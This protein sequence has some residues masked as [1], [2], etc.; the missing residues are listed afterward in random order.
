MKKKLLALGLSLVLSVSLLPIGAVAAAGPFQDISADHWASSAVNQL[1]QAGIMQGTG[2]TTF[3]PAGVF[4]RAMFV[5]ML[6]RLEQVAPK[7]HGDSR[8]SDVPTDS[9]YAPYVAWASQA[10]LVNGT[11]TAAFSPQAPITREQY[12]TILARYLQSKGKNL[13][14]DSSVSF[15]DQGRVSAYAA[16]SVQDMVS[17]GLCNLYENNRVWPKNGMTR[18]EIAGLFAGLCQWLKGEDGGIAI[19]AANPGGLYA[20]D[21]LGMTVSQLK[22][23]FGQDLIYMDDWKYGASL[24]MGYSDGRLPFVLYVTDESR[25]GYP[26]NNQRLNMVEY[27]G[28]DAVLL[29]PNI[30]SANSYQALLNKGVRGTLRQ[31][32]DDPEYFSD[33]G[34]TATCDVE[35]GSGVRLMLEWYN[36]KNPYSAQP[37]SCT[38]MD[39]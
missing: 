8:F 17:L 10:G 35:L 20:Q 15:G 14:H 11:S 31:E 39:W 22:A 3:G 30:S 25:R 18:V 23:L 9:W 2:E 16:Q 32:K 4:T 37:G 26:L 28:T 27:V 19:P 38:L 21:Y 7:P 6:G 36:S 12:C 13:H 5:T 34:A 24:G 1:Y 33:D 29:T